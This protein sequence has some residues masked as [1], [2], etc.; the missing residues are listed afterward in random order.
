MEGG[1]DASVLL[2]CG[3]GFMVGELACE[4]EVYVL[5][6]VSLQIVL[7]S[8]WVEVKKKWESTYEVAERRITRTST[9]PN[10]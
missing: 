8:C 2:N 1:D 6:Y 10:R 7:V 5:N 9:D 3:E 4:E